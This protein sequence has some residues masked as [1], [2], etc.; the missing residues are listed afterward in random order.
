[1]RQ[2]ELIG[3]DVDHSHFETPNPTSNPFQKVPPGTKCSKIRAYGGGG[4]SHF[5]HHNFP[6]QRATLDEMAVN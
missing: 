4:H 1:M 2:K 3:D 5:D 6:L